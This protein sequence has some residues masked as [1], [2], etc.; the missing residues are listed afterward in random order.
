MLGRVSPYDNVPRKPQ[1]RPSHLFISRHTN[2]DDI[3]GGTTQLLSP[4]MD[5][6]FSYQRVSGEFEEIDPSQV[7][8][9][10]GTGQ[11]GVVETAR[12]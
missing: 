4:L 3:L 10:E 9:H 5:T 12:M 7:K 8:I 11:K 2:I 1:K 6:I